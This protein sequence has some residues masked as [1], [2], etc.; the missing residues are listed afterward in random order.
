MK[1]TIRKATATLAVLATLGLAACGATTGETTTT[2]ATTSTSSSASIGSTTE[3]TTSAAAA[4]QMP[5]GGPGE[6]MGGGPGGVDPSSVTTEEELVALIQSAYGDA[7]LGLHRG[8][9]PVEEVLNEVLGISHDELHV[10]MDAGQNLATVADEVGVGQDA[11]VAA[12]VDSWSPAI[13]TLLA[14]GTIT[15][16][17]AD[18][19][20]ADLTEAF[21]YRVTWDG[22]SATPTYSG[23]AA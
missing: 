5:A 20:L 14:D 9:Q 15:Q 10:R 22:T 12:L 21:T 18:Q 23:L 17:E 4:P 7:G 6:G 3:G 11:L 16:D 8:H 19:Y 13:D 2:S 1:T